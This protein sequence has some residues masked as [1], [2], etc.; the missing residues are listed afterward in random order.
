MP[1]KEKVNNFISHSSMKNFLATAFNEH[2]VFDKKKC[3]GIQS[4]SWRSKRGGLSMKNRGPPQYGPRTYFCHQNRPPKV[5]P[6]DTKLGGSLHVSR[7]E[8]DLIREWCSRRNFVKIQH[9]SSIIY[10]TSFDQVL[11]E[12]HKE[13][14]YFVVG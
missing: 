1:I 13:R 6:C 11:L 14:S 4:S 2:E 3:L 8:L 7:Y 5:A 9:L 10:R 12:R